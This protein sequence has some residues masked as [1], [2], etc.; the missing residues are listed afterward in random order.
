MHSL[1]MSPCSRDLLVTSL[2][3]T[4]YNALKATDYQ[5]FNLHTP[6]GKTSPYL[7]SSCSY[8][9]AWCLQACVYVP[10]YV[11]LV[12]VYVCIFL[13]YD[14]ICDCLCKTDHVY[15]KTEIHFIAQDRT[16]VGTIYVQCLY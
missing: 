10:T 16:Y 12:H 11:N 1:V 2:N 5:W 3:T 15:T 6:D 14:C 7:L 9:Y 4:Y 13:S 8:I